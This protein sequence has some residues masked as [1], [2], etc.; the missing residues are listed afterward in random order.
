MKTANT[1]NPLPLS[2]LTSPLDEQQSTRLQTALVDLS[3]LQLAWV[4]GYLAGLGGLTTA[5][6]RS[7][8][9]PADAPESG[10]NLTILYG[11]QTGNTRTVAESL[12]ALVRA[13]GTEPRLLSM[14][15]YRPRDLARERLL[16]VVVSTQGEGEPP[17]SAR[18]LHAFLHGKRAPR[19]EGLR[20]GVLGLGDSSYEHFCKTAR[21]FDERFK[22]LGGQPL[23]APQYCDVAFQ[24]AASAWSLTALERAAEHLVPREARII[25]LP[26]TR[27]APKTPPALD[28]A[29]P[30]TA[31]LLENRI[32][33]TA[34]AVGEVH[35][36]ALGID[37]AALSYTPGDA[38]GV[39]FRNDPALV[40]AVLRATG[41]DGDAP[42]SLDGAAYDLREALASRLELTRLHPTVVKAWG[43]LIGS[44]PLA[45]LGQDPA[46]LRDYAAG[47]QF[48][49]LIAEHPGRP[50]AAALAAALHPLRPRLYS[51]AS[52]QAEFPD[53]VHLTIARVGYRVGGQERAGGASDFLTR[54]LTQ[55][56]PVAVHLATN[57]SFRLPH[58]GDAPVILIAAGTGVAPFR[59]FLQQ[60]A[61][62]GDRGRTWLVFGNRN[63]RRDFLYQL[64]WQAH[65]RA[66][67]LSR[68][69]VAFSRDQTDKRYVQHRLIEQGRELYT[70]LQEGAHL[71][72]CGANAMGRA[73]HEALLDLIAAQTGSDRED[74]GEQLTA[75]R[76]DGR[77]Q[78][79]LY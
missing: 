50:D 68:V 3:P 56:T 48:I 7:A 45:A 70:W 14:A 16:L 4:S 6:N 52:S 55:D 66:G 41:L 51:I 65:R 25:Q 75:L 39:W 2:P 71:Y 10:P 13:R 33:T 57:P 8:G 49:D 79:D 19:L 20:Y 29:A 76:R 35:N 28:Q 27:P 18:E 12:A 69:S 43:G 17:E 40:E 77:Y 54:R 72:V 58:D 60:R 23:L 1:L 26:G 30:L 9:Q 15:D 24:E 64:E 22:A 32:V 38:L 37:P 61:A 5:A 21:D 62:Q 78:R 36:L 63:F 34:D 44:E 46:R 53:E 67:V 74:A 59:A 31:H 11:S 47:R 42:L 73:V